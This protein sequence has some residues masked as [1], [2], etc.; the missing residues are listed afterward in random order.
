MTALHL[1]LEARAPARNVWRRYELSATCDLFGV[2][3]VAVTFGR[4]GAPGRTLS[5]SHLDEYAARRFVRACLRKRLSA[6]RR[7]GVAYR[8]VRCDDPGAWLDDIPALL[9]GRNE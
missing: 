3:C 9:S 5:S 2:W 7:I 1:V 8:V 4:I 6:P